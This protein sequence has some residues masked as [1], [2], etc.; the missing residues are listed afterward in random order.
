MATLYIVGNGFDLHHNLPTSLKEFRSFA[1]KSPFANAFERYFT[2]DDDNLDDI[3][4]NIEQNLAKFSIDELIE[5]K[6]TYHD[7]DPH[8]DQFNY[9]VEAEV[10]NLTEGL[11][12]EL[13]AYLTLADMQAVKPHTLLKLDRD[14]RY[15]NFN[16]TRTLE[17][18]YQIPSSN[19]CYIHG[20]LN[21]DMVPMVIG[22]G[23]EHH[24]YEPE[25]ENVD[26]TQL[27]EEQLSYYD[28]TH[29]AQYDEA[30]ETAY[31]Y[32]NNSI[33][34]TQNCIVRHQDFLDTLY[35]VDKIIILGHSLSDVDHPYFQWINDKVKSDCVWHVSYRSD[36]AEICTKLEC[37][38]NDFERMKFFEIS[39]LVL[40][41]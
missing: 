13:N 22:H 32:Y 19:I 29:S 20:M 38:V 10:Y 40:N 33:K 23:L 16:Y 17:R 30:M 31:S 24:E 12:K 9:E 7:N 4:G 26:V 2:F 37:I 39:A 5:D 27:T 3:W 11:V 14:C 21:S 28:D 25:L 35:D 1:N 34:D 15:I 18:I 36:K 41:Q 8:E 6:V